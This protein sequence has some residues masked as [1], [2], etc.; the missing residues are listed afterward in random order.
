MFVVSFALRP[1]YQRDF[2]KSI[3]KYPDD[4]KGKITI[5]TVSWT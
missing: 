5:K 4:V 3:L 1:L 2:L